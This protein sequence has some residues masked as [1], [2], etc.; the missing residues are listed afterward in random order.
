MK[1]NKIVLVD[2]TGLRDWA[3]TE[4]QKYSIAKIENHQDYPHTEL[5]LIKRIGTADGILV[6]WHTQIP[7][8]VIK[9]CPNLKYIGMC[10]SLYDEASANVDINYAGKKGIIVKGVRDYGDEG[11]VEFILAEIIRLIK[12]LGTHQWKQEPVELTRRRLGII[13]M[14]ATGKMLADRALAFNMEVSYFSRTRKMDVEKR[15][16][17]YLPLNQLLESS[18]IIS[19]HLPRNTILL[20][21]DHFLIMGGGKILVNTSLGLTFEKEGF[22]NWIQGKNNYAILDDDGVGQCKKEFAAHSNIIVSNKISGWTAEAIDRLSRK[23]IINLENFIDDT[24]KNIKVSF[25][26]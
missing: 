22:L 10:C 11:L 1:F 23:V 2:R 6:S 13:G 3:I 20:K 8:D 12:G 24:H 19:T 25:E 18:E 9:E 7:K 5:E 15:G 14:G 4:L 21:N 16:I 26:A 17:K